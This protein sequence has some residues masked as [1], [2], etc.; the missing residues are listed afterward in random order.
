MSLQLQSCRR[1]RLCWTLLILSWLIGGFWKWAN[2]IM[3]LCRE[4]SLGRNKRKLWGKKNWMISAVKMTS[5]TKNS[6]RKF[7]WNSISIRW[8]R[9]KW[10]CPWRTSLTISVK[11]PSQITIL[12]QKKFT[13]I[14]FSYISRQW[15]Q[16]EKPPRKRRRNSPQSWRRQKSKKPS[17]SMASSS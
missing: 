4:G 16:F 17:F 2:C 13:H 7:K 6:K 12:K 8:I 5:K 14:P 9:K 1:F 10:I 15:R 11:S 3:W